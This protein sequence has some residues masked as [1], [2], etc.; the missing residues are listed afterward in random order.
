[1]AILL[2]RACLAHQEDLENDLPV[3]LSSCCSL[4][5][6]FPPNVPILIWQRQGHRLAWPSFRIAQKL[7]KRPSWPSTDAEPD[8]RACRFGRYSVMSVGV[9]FPIG[10]CGGG[11]GPDLELDDARADRRIDDPGADTVVGRGEHDAPHDGDGGARDVRHPKSD[12]ISR[13]WRS[14]SSG[15]RRAPACDVARLAYW[16]ARDEAQRPRAA[17]RRERAR[18]ERSRARPRPRRPPCRRADPGLSFRAPRRAGRPRVSR[19]Y[20]ANRTTSARR[21]PVPPRDATRESRV[22]P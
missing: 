1:M 20:R 2:V 17:E 19:T 12:R 7:P 4:L 21:A 14:S 18:T 22:A 9:C 15:P 8:A 6:C 10:D 3:I 5:A 11:L 13:P 16:P